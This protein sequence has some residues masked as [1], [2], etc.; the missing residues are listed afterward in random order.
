MTRVRFRLMLGLARQE[1]ALGS[2]KLGGGVSRRERVPV[3]IEGHL[4]RGM[5]QATLHDLRRELE[6]AIRLR[7]D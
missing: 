7:V 4:N 3:G 5:P 6:A 1:G 2:G